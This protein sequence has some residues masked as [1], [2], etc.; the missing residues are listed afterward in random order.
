MI[1]TIHI[2]HFIQTA[3]PFLNGLVLR[4]GGC[5]DVTMPVHIFTFILELDRYRF[6][7]S[8]SV[9]GFLVGFFKSRYRFRCRF[10]KIS[11]YRFR[12]SVFPHEPTI[13]YRITPSLTPYALPFAPNGVWPLEFALQIAALR[14]RDIVT[15]NRKPIGTHHHSI[16]RY[17]RR[18]AAPSPS[19]TMGNGVPK[20]ALRFAAKQ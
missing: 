20:F 11:L 17:Y 18:P 6:F 1:G 10:F 13:A 7:K 8:V 15:Y 2:A 19:P 4:L 9:L 16:E 3:T 12:F 14:D 5:K